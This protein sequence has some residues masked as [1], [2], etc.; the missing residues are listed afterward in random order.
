MLS[1]R[2]YE[3]KDFKNAQYICLNSDEGE[4]SEELCEFLL[5]VFCDYYIEH[6]PDNCFVLDDG[7]RAVGYIICAEDYDTY[8][9]IFDRDYLPLIKHC[10]DDLYQWGLVS[11]VLQNKYKADYPAH[12]HIDLLPQYQHQG[13]GGKLMNALFEHLKKK[14]VRGVILSTGIDN[15]NAGKFYKKLGFKEIEILGTEVAFGI[16][17]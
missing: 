7:G 5:H 16:K 14:G 1:I 2:K 3:E 11:T 12:L 15:V 9:E 4:M 13:W 17:L 10:S 6:E 8:K